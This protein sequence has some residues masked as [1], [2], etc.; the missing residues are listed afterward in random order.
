MSKPHSPLLQVQNLSITYRH[1]AGETLAVRD[2]SCSLMAGQTLALVGASGSGKSSVGLGIMRLLPPQTQVG[3]S[4]QLAG[5]NLLERSESLMDAARGRELAMVFQ[6]PMTALNP[7]HRIGKQLSEAFLIHQT[8]P[9]QTVLD[10]IETAL[11]DV[12]LRASGDQ[13]TSV[14]RILR[15]YPHQL[16]GGQ[17][18][19]VLLAMAL[20]NRP[21]LLI[22]DEPTTALDAESRIGLIHLLKQLQERHQLSLLLIS[23]HLS[24][25]RALADQVVVMEGGVAVE[26]GPA[27]QLLDTPSHAYTK[28]LLAAD[29]LPKQNSDLTAAPALL[30]ATLRRH[31]QMVWQDPFSSLNPRMMVG[32]L[33][34]EGLGLIRPRLDPSSQNTMVAEALQAVELAPEL[35][36]RYPHEL[37]G[38]QRQRVA[39]A[40][41]LI[42]RPRL[43]ILDE[44]TSALDA[45]TQAQVIALLK[46]LQSEHGLSYL[47]I[48]HDPAVVAAL[49]HRV[50]T[51]K[52]AGLQAVA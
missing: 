4:V 23:H 46:K 32:D 43:L 1:G 27:A 52:N 29:H 25:V 20:L 50:L 15:A 34:A 26:Q 39:I 41:A 3:G 12:G 47:L 24:M 49:S 51:L 11:G 33:V 13:P 14:Q 37:S 45:L 44:P 42:L 8:A 40:R 5:E 35:A 6:E 2:L 18:Q 16:S 10:A 28:A 21:S 22:L 17:R 31:I 9:R 38:G 36:N 19:R 48:S 30:T 7:L